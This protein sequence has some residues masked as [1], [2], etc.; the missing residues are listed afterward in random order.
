M[1]ASATVLRNRMLARARLRHVHIF[2]KTVDLGSVRLA[3]E[4]VGVAQPSATQALADLEALLECTLFL[5]HSRGMSPTAAG[6]ALLPLA[7]R[8]LELVDE[9]ATHIAAV[10]ERATTLVRVASITAAIPALLADALPAFNK[11]HPEV[12]V[13]LVEADSARQ[14]ALVASREIDLAVC[15]Q[16]PTIPDGWAFTSLWADRFTIV[17]A[18]GHPLARRQ[19][20]DMEELWHAEWLTAPVSV[21]ARRV[22]DDLFSEAPRPPHAYSVVT[23]AP[24]LVMRLLKDEGLLA[25][26]PVS[27]VRRELDARE[28]FEIGLDRKMRVDDI[29]VLLTTGDRDEAVDKLFA[30]LLRLRKAAFAKNG[31][32]TR[33][34]KRLS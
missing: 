30:Y 8:M 1:P 5:R 7:R 22:L 12:V 15:R 20:V 6:H 26:L 21:A 14:A 11:A 25:V 3:A 32:G 31:Q 23:A 24:G 33:R 19:R 13:Q 28:L 34:R 9:G 16:P 17:C 10:S 29:G 27:L 18:P 4:A 2:V